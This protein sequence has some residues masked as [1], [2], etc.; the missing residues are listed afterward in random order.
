[1][2]QKLEDIDLEDILTRAITVYNKS[3]NFYTL[4]K[5]NMNERKK[6]KKLRLLGLFPMVGT[7]IKN[8]QTVHDLSYNNYLDTIFNQKHTKK[9][10]E[11]IKEKKFTFDLYF[12]RGY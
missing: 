5:K 11:K 2:E 8:Y 7:L 1:M 3:Y 9:D 10:I 6:L 4:S 12:C